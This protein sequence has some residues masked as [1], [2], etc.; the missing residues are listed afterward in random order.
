MVEVP[1][2][3]IYTVPLP[4]TS[5]S[6]ALFWQSYRQVGSAAKP[7]AT[8]PKA[9]LNLGTTRLSGHFSKGLLIDNRNA[10]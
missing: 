3:R 1:A 9:T 8:L 10:P 5:S 4:L 2:A 7:S 6:V